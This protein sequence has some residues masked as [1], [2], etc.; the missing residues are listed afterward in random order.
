MGRGRFIVALVAVL[1]AALVV[2][3][4]YVLAQPAGDPAFALPILD[5]AYY[6]AWAGGLASGSGGPPGAFYLA[7]LYPYLLAAFLRAFGE[8]FTLLYLLQHLLMLGAAA[9]LAVAARRAA[10]DEAGLAAAAL[11]LLYHPSCFFASRP[12]GESVA[13]LL[14]ATAATAVGGES[15]ADA[16]W[17]GLAAGAAALA[18]PNFLLAAVFW[19]AAELRRRRAARVALLL[20]G[21]ALAIAPVALRNLSAS[22]HLVLVS[23]NG[24]MTLYHGNGPG[25]LGTYTPAQGFSGELSS[26]RDEA[27]RRASA[28]AGRDF[29]PVEAD[30][31]WGRQAVGTRLHDPVGTV[32]LFGRRLLLSL[33][34]YEHSVDYAP[35]LDADPWSRAAPVPFAAILGLAAVGAVLAGTKGTGGPPVWGAI[36]AAAATPLLFYVSSRYRLPLAALLCVPAGVGFV[37]LFDRPARRPR[38]RLLT[39]IVGGGLLAAVSLSVPFA[40][41]RTVEEAAALANR[42]GSY[43][44]AGDLKAA[45]REV[46]RALEID[47][48]SQVAWLNLGIILEAERRIKEAK[49]SYREALRLDPTSTAA[50]ENLAGVLILHGE[51]K[52]AVGV[53]RRALE[54]DPS[55]AG[56]W[57]NLV[58]ALVTL[59][60][61]AAARSEAARAESAGVALDPSLLDL[62]AKLAAA[63]TDGG[64]K[65]ETE[66]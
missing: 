18:R 23:S 11:F 44:R 54:A 9:A 63:H 37:A 58:V 27:T 2:R 51:A 32:L 57:A 50:A 19:V 60:D 14:I 1:L 47:P 8:N 61:P 52:E 7:P 31:W 12:M 16:G 24:G 17:G 40:N 48:K 15:R 13:L 20:G 42:A 65:E 21:I 28:L 5:G 43:K 29:D 46:R 30:R 6:L 55:A 34:N 59:N 4:G 38:R 3:V 64:R 22:G 33:D 53:L 66:R 35:E 62:V 25:A 39:A 26:Q 10:G 49:E 45:E 56:C 41:L 36:A